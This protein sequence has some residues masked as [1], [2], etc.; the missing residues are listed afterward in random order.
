MIV[1]ELLI[2]LGNEDV[3]IRVHDEIDEK[4]I[5]K[6]WSSTYR[7]MPDE[8]PTNILNGEI[9]GVYIDIDGIDIYTKD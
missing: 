7:Y 2:V 1:K 9:D 8:I 3:L 4:P 6:C 5:Y